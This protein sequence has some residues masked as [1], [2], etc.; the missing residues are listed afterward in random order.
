M[1]IVLAV[2]FSMWIGFGQPRPPPPVLSFS[3]Q[4]CTTTGEPVHSNF[5]AVASEFKDV[6]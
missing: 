6:E 2:I 5:R 1:G 3:T 4:N